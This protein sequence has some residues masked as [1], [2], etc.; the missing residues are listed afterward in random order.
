M[1]SYHCTPRHIVWAC[2]HGRVFPYN[3]IIYRNLFC[4][5]LEELPYNKKK[6]N[7]QRAPLPD[8]FQLE[9]YYIWSMKIDCTWGICKEYLDPCNEVFIN[10]CPSFPLP[11][12]RISMRPYHKASER[13]SAIKCTKKNLQYIEFIIVLLKRLK[14]VAMYCVN[15]NYLLMETFILC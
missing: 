6:V 14:V 9:S 8:P 7:N 11:Q 12:I 2:H 4:D 10:Q 3:P 13:T 5:M 1:R 15:W